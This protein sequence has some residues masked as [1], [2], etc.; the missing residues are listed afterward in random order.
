MRAVTEYEHDDQGLL[1]RSVTTWDPETTAEDR[2][3]ATAWLEHEDD[4]C[5]GCGH[6][7]TES[8]DEANMRSY[9][10]VETTCWACMQLEVARDNVAESG[11]RERGIYYGTMLSA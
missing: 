8:H 6:P 1:V 11:E 5:A 9:E 3:W 10:L 7:R 2:G 4:L